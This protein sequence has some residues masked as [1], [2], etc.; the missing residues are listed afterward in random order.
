MCRDKG[1]D[2]LCSYCTADPR[3]CYRIRILL[4]FLCKGPNENCRNKCYKCY[5][6]HLRQS[7]ILNKPDAL[8][9][10]GHYKSKAILKNG[11]GLKIIKHHNNKPMHQS[12][13]TTTLPHLRGSAGI[14]TFQLSVPSYKPQ[15]RGQTGGQT[16]ALCSDLKQQS[17]S[18]YNPN[19]RRAY[20]K[21]QH[22]D[23][24][25]RMKINLFL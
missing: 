4:V 1:A 8:Y 20:E 10:W 6:C 16:I 18:S 5:K 3:P 25:G 14:L 12:F 19:A 15:P 7:M 24:F 23:D 22:A 2:Q 17:H 9:F 11:N 13:V 21:S